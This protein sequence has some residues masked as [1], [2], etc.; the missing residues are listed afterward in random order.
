MKKIL[1]LA[2]V[3]TGLSACSSHMYNTYSSGKDNASFIII[4]TEGQSYEDVSVIVDG[5]T[6]SIEKVY[7]VKAT[8]KAHPIIT[9]PGKHQIKVVSKGKTLVEESVMIG[10]QET[11][12]IIL[13]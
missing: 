3:I 11:K 9:T 13:K 5:K 10:L 12:K 6:F 4:L 2:F 1:I 7:P 8:L